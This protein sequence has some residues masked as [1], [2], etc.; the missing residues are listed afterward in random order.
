[1]FVLIEFQPGDRGE[2]ESVE[3]VSGPF[4]TEKDAEDFLETRISS[5]D[6]WDDGHKHRTKYS[7]IVVMNPP[8]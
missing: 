5:N 8:C 6:Y 3:C 1:M 4:E 7:R 2:L